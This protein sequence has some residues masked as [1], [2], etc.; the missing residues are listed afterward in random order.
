VQ[1]APPVDQLKGS[2]DVLLFHALQRGLVFAAKG[3]QAIG[4]KTACPIDFALAGLD[5]DD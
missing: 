2:I 3:I 1:S 5:F 4:S